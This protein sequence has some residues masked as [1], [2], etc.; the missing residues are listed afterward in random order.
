MLPFSNC[1]SVAVSMPPCSFSNG[2]PSDPRKVSFSSSSALN[3]PVTGISD[4]G[5]CFTVG[6]VVAVGVAVG[7]AVGIAVGE[8]VAVGAIVAVGTGGLVGTRVLLAAGG[9]VGALVGA[10][11]GGGTA[12]DVL[13]G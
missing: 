8:V 5:F 1:C 7:A 4:V 10:D 2:S 11:V 3:P 12:V 6:A 13:V 9:L